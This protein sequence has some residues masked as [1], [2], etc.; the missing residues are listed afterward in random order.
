MNMLDKDPKKQVTKPEL[1]KA[2]K[3]AAN[4]DGKSV[5]PS[6]A[7]KLAESVLGEKDQLPKD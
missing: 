7:D 4:D 6:S 3:D 1:A 2:I 5:N